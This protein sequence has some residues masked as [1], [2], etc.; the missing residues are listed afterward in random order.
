MSRFLFKLALVAL[1]CNP[2]Y[3]GSIDRR[4]MVKASLDKNLAKLYPKNKLGVVV[5]TCNPR[6]SRDKDRSGK[7]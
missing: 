5:L 7:V 2:N 6:C 3:S 4:L 1:A